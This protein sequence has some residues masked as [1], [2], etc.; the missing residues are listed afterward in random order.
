MI[1]IRKKKRYRN[2]IIDN[3]YQ[4]NFF[5]VLFVDYFI[6]SLWFIAGKWEIID[7]SNRNE[8]ITYLCD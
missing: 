4:L 6:P 3:E 8:L 7:F 1:A 2:N 5:K